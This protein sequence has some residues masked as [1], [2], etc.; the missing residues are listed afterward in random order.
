MINTGIVESRIFRETTVVNQVL[1]HSC[2]LFVITY[3]HF[4]LKTQFDYKD[5]SDLLHKMGN[6]LFFFYLDRESYT[7]RH[8]TEHKEWVLTFIGASM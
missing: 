5:I 6:L 8:V 7:K 2:F 1:Y 3:S 4:S